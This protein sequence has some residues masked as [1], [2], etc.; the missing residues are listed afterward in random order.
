MGLGLREN[1]IKEAGEEAGIPAALASTAVPGGVVS[2]TASAGAGGG[3]KRDVLFV[4]DLQLPPSFNPSP[5]D[6]EVSAFFLWPISRVKQ[7]L[8][9]RPNEYKVRCYKR[10][11]AGRLRCCGVKEAVV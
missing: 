2:Y 6:G 3:V 11:P 9:A 1:V 7:A 4:F 10:A 5:S 8:R